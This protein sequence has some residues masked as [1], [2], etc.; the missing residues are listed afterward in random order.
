MNHVPG[1]KVAPVQYS[2]TLTILLWLAVSTGLAVSIFSLIEELCLA[3]ACSDAASFT[4]FGIGMAWLGIAYFSLILLVLW[5]RPKN[6]LLDWALTALLFSGIGAE[7]RLLWI[8][9][10]IIGSWCPL[11]VTICSALFFAG[12]VLLIGKVHE[13]G[14]GQ[15]R[16]K[17]LLG[18]LAFVMAMAAIGLAVAV[19]GVQALT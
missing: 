3:T 2:R 1:R 8:Q 5:L 12:I 17:S 14:S 11:C 15:G 7:F 19:V 10:Y 16:G 6:Y 18:W 9:K 4:F 13:S